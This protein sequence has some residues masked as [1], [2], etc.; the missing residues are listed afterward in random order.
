MT[1]PSTTTTEQPILYPP[2]PLGRYARTAAT[3]AKAVVSGA[4]RKAGITVAE[5]SERA[6]ADVVL[7]RPDAFYTRLGVDGLIG[8][9]ES[10]VAGDWEAEDLA[11]TLTKLCRR[12]T[13]LVPGWRQKLRG[14]YSA[15]RPFSQKNTVEGAK[16]NISA[17]YDLSNDFFGTFLDPGLNYSSALFDGEA[18][19]LAQAQDAKIER[20]LDRARVGAG[21]RVLEIGTGW[22]ELALHAARRGAEVQSVT[23]SVEQ[24]DLARARVADAGFADSVSIDVLDYREVT[25]SFDAVVSIEMIEAV[26]AEYWDEYMATV[27]DRLAP[28]GRAVIQAITMDH[29]QVMATKNDATWI[30]SYIFPGGVIPSVTA[31]DGS[32][33]RAGLSRGMRTSFGRDY[34]ETLHRWDDAF[35]EAVSSGRVEELGFGP[36]FQRLWHFYLCYCEAGFAADYIDVGQ[37]EYVR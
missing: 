3:V 19:T 29:D 12:I 34:A 5:E 25:G 21:T 14:L 36:D 7:R 15:A 24:A 6:D 31:L 10:Y 28:G 30:T 4:A 22:G 23:L 20:V 27:H 8:F 18:R 2:V 9:G 13:T 33:E 32:A 16:R 35:L 26:G 11:G 1:S 37:L 17:H